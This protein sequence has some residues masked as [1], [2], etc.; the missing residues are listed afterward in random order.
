MGNKIQLGVELGAQ[1]CA[2]FFFFELEHR[3]QRACSRIGPDHFHQQGACLSSS[4][5]SVYRSFPQSF[6]SPLT[7]VTRR[8][9]RQVRGSGPGLALSDRPLGGGDK[10]ALHPRVCVVF[11]RV[12]PEGYSRGRT[13]ELTVCTKLAINIATLEELSGRVLSDQTSDDCW[14]PSAPAPPLFSGTSCRA[15][16]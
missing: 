6:M 7:P 2:F 1:C 4:V 12:L 11:R 13:T 16:M 9:S 10:L 5:L 15:Q 3:S 8:R 14:T